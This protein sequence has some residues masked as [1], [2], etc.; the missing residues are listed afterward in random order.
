M[1]FLGKAVLGGVGRGEDRR[2]E[3]TR[4]E[5]IRRHLAQ[6]SQR[7]R[8]KSSVGYWR[9]A[10]GVRWHAEPS[11]SHVSMGTGPEE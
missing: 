5:V 2:R 8:L 10:G 9:G 1:L 3:K 6:P 11:R 4:R 7:R